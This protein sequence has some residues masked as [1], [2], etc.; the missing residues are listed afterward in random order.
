MIIKIWYKLQ[1][2]AYEDAIN[3]I[4]PKLSTLFEDNV[5]IQSISDI[6]TTLQNN[7]CHIKLDSLFANGKMGL[8]KGLID[9]VVLHEVFPGW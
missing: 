2:Q 5:L 4:R 3:K 7:D 9:M 8:F 1:F 6:P